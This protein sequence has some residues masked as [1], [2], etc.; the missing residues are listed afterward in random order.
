MCFTPRDQLASDTPKDDCGD[1]T[2]HWMKMAREVQLK[3]GNLGKKSSTSACVCP[4]QMFYSIFFLTERCTFE[5]GK[6]K[7]VIK[8]Y[9][10]D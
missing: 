9:T 6:D 5:L 2:T 4:L 1:V 8:K 7:I 3:F 10:F